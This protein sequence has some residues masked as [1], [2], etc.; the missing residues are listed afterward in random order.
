MLPGSKEVF[1]S[2]RFPR[3]PTD[4]FEQK[5]LTGQFAPIQVE[6]R[7]GR[8]EAEFCGDVACAARRSLLVR[9]VLVYQPINLSN[10][11]RTGQF[12]GVQVESLQSRAAAKFGRNVACAARRS[13]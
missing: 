8:A 12:V 10:K 5:V 1:F 2:S 6:V 4:Q 9:A 13:F 11:L 7:H 3:T